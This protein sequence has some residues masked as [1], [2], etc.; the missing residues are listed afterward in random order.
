MSLIVRLKRSIDS[1]QDKVIMLESRLAE[2]EAKL[3]EPPR[4]KP[5]RKPKAANAE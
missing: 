3:I 5:G 1:L 2:I 4:R